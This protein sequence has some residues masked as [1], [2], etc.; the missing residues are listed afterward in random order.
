MNNS[1]S[2]VNTVLNDSLK[3]KNQ[4]L[5]DEIKKNADDSIRFD[6]KNRMIYLY[7]NAKIEYQNTTISA[8]YIEIDWKENTIYA[9][10]TLD[11]INQKIGLPVFK[12]GQDVFQADIIKYNFK[13]K[14]SYIKQITTKEGEGY[15]LGKKVKKTDKD[16]FY[17]HKGDYTTCDAE[18]P[19]YSIRS[20]KV[21]V[22]PGDKIIT[23]P[24]YLTF[25]GIPTP[26]LFPFGYF[27]NNN[28]QSS[29][30]LIPS[31]GESENFGFFLKNGGYYFSLNN[32]SD[33]S[34]RSD[35]YTNGSWA[36]R[37]NLRYKKRYRYN[38]N[39]N[40]SYSNII[41]S[42]KGFP[43]YSIK[44]D[45]FLKWRHNQDPKSNPSLQFSSNVNAGSSTFHRNNL[46]TGNEYLNNTFQSSINIT[47]K[48][49]GTPFNLSANL[50]HSQNTQTK[51]VNLSVPDISLN[52]RRI[53]PFKKTKGSIRDAWYSK[54]G[55]SYNMNTKNT[56]TI[57]DSLLFRKEALNN[58]RY[59]MK[60]SIP[61]ST[62]V[63]LLNHFTLSPSINLTER[64][65]LSQINKRWD[66]N[67]LITDTLNKFT[68]AHS[69]SFS[70]NL[71]TKIYGTIM[72]K[73]TK[74]AAV[75]HV[76]SPN[77]SFTYKPDFSDNKYGYY[78]SVQIDSIGNF[79]KYSIMQNGIFGSP[80]Q[81]R[82]GNINL[83]VS[84]I[85]EM[86]IRNKKD[87][88]SLKK[89]K[90]FENLNI[91]SS[92]NIFKDS[93]NLS[94]INLNARTRILDVFDINFS[95]RYDP[96][97]SNAEK[98]NNLNKLEINTNKRIARLTSFTT[99]VGVNINNKTFIN[100]TESEEEKFLIP[101][102][103]RANYSLTYNKG[104]KS[105]EF[106][107]T[108]QNLNFSGDINITKKWKLGFR[109]GYDF[110]TKDLSYT[111]ID[112]YR[113]LHCWEM[114]FNWIPIGF[115]RSYTLT[116]RVKASVLRDLKYEKKK[117]WF[118]P[119]FN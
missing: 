82:T 71:N 2:Q 51:I 94:M 58:L 24:A 60:H 91:S 63:K 19:H 12:E 118:I 34:F 67:S 43:D 54:I 117:E 38:G 78:K 113:D 81:V 59:G 104:Y 99:S 102:N 92:Y 74:I 14:K 109:S 52:M 3:M 45:F 75:R 32:K 6:I 76:I 97:V 16:I 96:Y 37:S 72:L 79:Q 86:K 56:I 13:T 11:S 90:I 44:K 48:W 110:D 61:F 1:Y 119:E 40:I 84:N 46:S 80:S 101:W 10:Y 15:I 42:E 108:I 107:D 89:V 26:L 21:K 111:S 49:E 29:G 114:L 50:R 83:S 4:L 8:D 22:I 27:P 39:L 77:I 57:A 5:D 100:N 95:S 68:R 31:Y 23:G 103:L 53:F 7:G 115:H 55:I 105:S 33:L 36:M 64:W 17:I 85:L 62:S 93:L 9:T 20:N 87:T 28:K 106:A 112:I 41:N 66:G 30:I 73:K 25:F 98:N 65:Y 18:K 116:I 35:I 47:K 69:Y 88:V 70:A